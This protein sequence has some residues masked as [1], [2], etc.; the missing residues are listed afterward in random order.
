MD[1]NKESKIL[2]VDDFLLVRSMLKKSLAEI[3]LNNVEEAKNGEEALET[4]MTAHTNNEPFSIMFLD[5]SMPKM[6][7]FGVLKACREDKRFKDLPIFM[8][9][10]ESERSKITR[11]AELGVTDYIIK[12]F[13]I[14]IIQ[15]KLVKA[16]KEQAA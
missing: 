2:V 5:W 11:A 16:L 10:A 7:G 15:E 12:P 14:N 6:D 1:L 4:L 9:T 8:V 13:I 3:G